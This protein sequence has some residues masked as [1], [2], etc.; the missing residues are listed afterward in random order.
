M[1]KVKKNI[2]KILQEAWQSGENDTYTE[3]ILLEQAQLYINNLSIRLNDKEVERVID[4]YR[5][6][7][8][9]RK[10]KIIKKK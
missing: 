10:L 3:D 2:N 7:F 9:G 8:L 6:G 4:A 1:T 5:N